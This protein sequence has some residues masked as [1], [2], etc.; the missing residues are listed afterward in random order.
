MDAAQNNSTC[1]IRAQKYA[2]PI[3]ANNAP[4]TIVVHRILMIQ[5]T[6]VT[7]G[8]LLTSTSLWIFIGFLLSREQ[9]GSFTHGHETFHKR[10]AQRLNLLL[11]F[12]GSARCSLANCTSRCHCGCVI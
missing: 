9:L 6:S 7:S 3:T 12:C 10:R 4:H 1:E 8:T 11:R 5:K 2:A